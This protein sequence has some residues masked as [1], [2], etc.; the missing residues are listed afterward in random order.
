VLASRGLPTRATPT[1]NA[2]NLID[3]IQYGSTADDFEF[4]DVNSSID[5]SPGSSSACDQEATRLPLPA[6]NEQV[7]LKRGALG[8]EA[9][10]SL[11]GVYY[12]SGRSTSA[13]ETTPA[14]WL[15]P[16]DRLRPW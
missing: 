7:Y 13:T 10:P 8:Y 15:C 2:Q 14:R 4:D 12:K 1:G 16:R 9:R 3:F 6:A 5:I 11:C